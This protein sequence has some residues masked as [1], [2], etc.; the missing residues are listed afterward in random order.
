MTIDSVSTWW[1]EVRFALAA[2]TGPERA[3]GL[4]DLFGATPFPRPFSG[5]IRRRMPVSG[6]SRFLKELSGDTGPAARLLASPVDGGDGPDG[7]RLVLVWPS[8]RPA[9]LADVFPV[10]ENLG[11]RIVGHAAYDIRPAGRPAVR[12]E[13]FALLPRDVAALADVAMRGLVTGRVRGGVV[14]RGRRTTGSTSW[15]SGPG[16]P[17][18][19]W[20]CCG[21]CSPTCVRPGAAFSQALRRAHPARP[22]GR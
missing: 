10:L 4:V 13:E 15:S 14:R 9:L 16:C 22:T 3:E 20:R 17:G 11:L 1:D 21:P 18:A 2:R 7:T 19:R 8:P 5:S 6:S 12:V